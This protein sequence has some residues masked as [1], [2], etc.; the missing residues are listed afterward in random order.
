MRFAG[1]MVA[2]KL[3]P[4]NERDDGGIYYD[5]P[6][7]ENDPDGNLVPG[8]TIREYV[9][10]NGTVIAFKGHSEVQGTPAGHGH[11]GNFL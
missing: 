1:Q 3:L 9:P 5:Q 7:L 4:Y 8:K 6:T 10:A 11:L 2:N